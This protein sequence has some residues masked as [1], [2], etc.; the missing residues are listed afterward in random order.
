[1]ARYGA[2]YFCC[3]IFATISLFP[4]RPIIFVSFL[5][6]YFLMQLFHVVVVVARSYHPVGNDIMMVNKIAKY[7]LF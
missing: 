7:G 1:M 6:L 3:L 2:V 5:Q 4:L